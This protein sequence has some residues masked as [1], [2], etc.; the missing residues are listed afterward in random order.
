MTKAIFCSTLA[1]LGLVGPQPHH[2]QACLR[3]VPDRLLLM[4]NPPSLHT[5]SCRLIQEPFAE[6]R[7]TETPLEVTMKYKCA[8]CNK[9]KDM[10]VMGLAQHEE[11]A[12]HARNLARKLRELA[13]AA[14]PSRLSSCCL[15]S[16]NLDGSSCQSAH[17]SDG[18]SSGLT[19][20]PCRASCM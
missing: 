4:M 1:T 20:F 11:G 5:F 19:D 16:N 6:K 10:K 8:V 12:G 15:A 7:R 14:L 17:A 2:V 18:D 9:G 3:R 13:G